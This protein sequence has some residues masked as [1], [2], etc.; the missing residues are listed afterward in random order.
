[1]RS[2]RRSRA[3]SRAQYLRQLAIEAEGEEIDR[4]DDD[5][6]PGEN[7]TFVTELDSGEYIWY[8]PVA[9]HRQLGME[10]T[11]TVGGG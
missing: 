2:R 5:V 4:T 7:T 6:D 11:L 1:V 9:N 8:C 3:T 10:G